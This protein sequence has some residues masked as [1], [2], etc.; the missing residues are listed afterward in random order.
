MPNSAALLKWAKEKTQ[1]SVDKAQVKLA[2]S[3][4]GKRIKSFLEDG[5]YP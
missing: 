1:S 2:S 4:T 5:E 3:D